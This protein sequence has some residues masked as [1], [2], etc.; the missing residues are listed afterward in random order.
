MTLVAELQVLLDESG[1]ATFWTATHLYN[2]LNEAH[3]QN[4]IATKRQYIATP[5]VVMGGVTY[6]E[7]PPEILIPTFIHDDERR[8]FT[9]TLAKL[10]QYSPQWK[11]A[12]P[13]IPK[14]FV[15]FGYTHLRPWP[16]P[17][18]N[19]QYTLVGLGW[20]SEISESVTDLDLPHLCRQA[21]L[22][23]AGA[24]LIDFTHPQLSE[25]W[26]QNATEAEEKYLRQQ[27]NSQSHNLRTLRPSNPLNRAQGGSIRNI[28]SF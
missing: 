25:V 6:V 24:S 14:A 28:Q 4:W 3:L 5:L 23:R 18:N 1:G 17:D 12:T 27:R 26:Q 21:V 13:S 20:P 11:A 9:T 8:Y 22:W 19:Y 10:E 7:I 2:A 16:M 15:R